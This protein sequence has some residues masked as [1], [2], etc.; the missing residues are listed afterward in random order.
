MLSELIGYVVLFDMLPQALDSRLR[1]YHHL[2]YLH[3]RSFFFRRLLGARRGL[4]L[5][6]GKAIALALVLTM[7]DHDYLHCWE[8]V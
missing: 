3:Q 2:L 1:V 8:P 7:E 5:E 4:K 6:I